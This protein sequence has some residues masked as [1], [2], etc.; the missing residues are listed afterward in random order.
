MGKYKDLDQ[1]RVYNSVIKIV[2]NAILP[3]YV[4]PYSVD[5]Q[6]QSIGAGFFIDNQGHAL[7]AAHVVEDSV[8]LWIKLPKYGQ[9]IFTAEI[10]CVYPDFDL[11][12]IKVDIENE[13]YLE[14]GNSDNISL[15]DIVYTIGYPHDP[16]YPII[17][18][19]TQR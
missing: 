10:I 19:G 17:T 8:E 7:T 16:K 6:T 13:H 4:M 12:I 1:E 5:K 15:R 3:N 11:A 2:N 14:L 18:T 9:K